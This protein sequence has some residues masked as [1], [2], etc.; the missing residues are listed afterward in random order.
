MG[1][2]HLFTNQA[3]RGAVVKVHV[4]LVNPPYPGGVSGGMDMSLGLGY[5]AAV[6]EKNGYA[7]DVIDCQL[8]KPTQKELLGELIRR[9]PDVV[10]VSA[11]T[12]T[13]RP[14]LE[15]VKTAKEFCPDC[16]TILGG[17]HVTVMGE[18]TLSE[19]PEVDIAVRGEG[20]QTMLELADLISESNLKDLDKVAGINFRKNGKIVQTPDR[21]FI[22]NLDELPFPAHKHF[23]LNKYRIF[24]KMYLPIITSRGCP[25]Q[26]AFCIAAVMCGRRFRAR[27]PKNVVD[28]LEWLRDTCRVDAVI[29]YDDVFTFDKKRAL[30]I[31]EEMKN[32]KVGLPWDARTRVDLVSKEILVKMRDAN[33]QRVLFGIESGSQQVLNNMKKGTTVE[34]GERAIKWAKEAGLFV[35]VNLIFG[36]PGETT[37][38]RKQTVDFVR[39]TKP[40]TASLFLATPYPGTE[41]RNL[42]EK[43]GWKMSSNWSLYETLTPVFENPLL[44]SEE[45]RKIRKTFYNDFYSPSYILHHSLKGIRGNFYSRIMARTALNF[46]LWRIKLPT[47]VYAIFKKLTLE[48]GL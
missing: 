16:L 22:Q 37:D 13:Y 6:L 1:F 46:L 12:I 24:G 15:I 40:D 28:E 5:L 10:G 43:M 33:C 35:D 25:F 19:Q 47:W 45:I 26:C 44:P 39:K 38:M 18:Q 42:V 31:C 21:P 2:S 14:A 9:R 29:F 7:V 36:Y 8:L 23:P 17:A 32:R 27:S 20:E 48:I 34:Q 41:L 3:F 11:T 30:K 4:T